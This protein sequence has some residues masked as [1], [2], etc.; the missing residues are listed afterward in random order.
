M[1]ENGQ[2]GSATGLLSGLSRAVGNLVRAEMDLAKVEMTGKATE[3]GKDAGRL[4]AGGAVAYLGS[5]VLL[6]SLVR[7]LETFLPRWLAA[8]VVGAVTT[9]GGAYV[10]QQ[11]L[12]RL[13]EADLTPHQVVSTLSKLRE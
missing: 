9:G 12:Q 8:F 3:M 7:M 2:R 5:F 1:Q 6:Q 10:V 11:E 13:K 4:A